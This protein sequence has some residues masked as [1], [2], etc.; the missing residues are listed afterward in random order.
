MVITGKCWSV[1]LT[2][3]G[4]SVAAVSLQAGPEGGCPGGGT[5]VTGKAPLG[6]A[7]GW[8]PAPDESTSG[9]PPAS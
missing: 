7:V 1:V 8:I 9:V 6:A 5:T 3:C 4:A 2:L